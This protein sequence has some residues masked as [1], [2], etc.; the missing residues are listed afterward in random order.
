MLKLLWADIRQF[1][2]PFLFLVLTIPLLHYL[3]AVL[4]HY[5]LPTRFDAIV[6]DR[7]VSV[8][9]YFAGAAGW[10]FAIMA[11]IILMLFSVEPGVGSQGRLPALLSLP[12]S[13]WQVGL[14]R[15]L[16]AMIIV[17]ALGLILNF[18]RWILESFYALK[19]TD[20]W[21]LQQ[22]I[23]WDTVLLC[24]GWA[25]DKITN[26]YGLGYANV[27]F[28]IAGWASLSLFILGIP[29]L[30]DDVVPNLRRSSFS[31][32]LSCSLFLGLSLQALVFVIGNT[33]QLHLV[34]HIYR[35]TDFV[36]GVPLWQPTLML[37]EIS[38]ALAILGLELWRFERRSS[39]V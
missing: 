13:R 17:P 31:L 36:S 11:S 10:L 28:Q 8:N 21:Q 3:D 16:P 18:Y 14:L 24:A 1:K 22:T 26:V 35:D 39:Y 6:G 9:E 37:I 15:H 19:R 38:L 7:T 4:F 25:F 20:M 23:D 33:F 5:V 12:L 2:K 32:W 29:L 30:V 27:L 34:P